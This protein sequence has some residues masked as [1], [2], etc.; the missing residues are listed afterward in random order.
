MSLIFSRRWLFL[1]LCFLGASFVGASYFLEYV[2]GLQ[3]CLLCWLQRWTL[4][5]FA[6]IALLCFFAARRYWLSFLLNVLLLLVNLFG[7]FFAGRQVWLQHL[8][9]AQGYSCLPN[10]SF[11]LKVYSLKKIMHLSFIGTPNC[12]LVHGRILGLSLAQWALIVFVGLL[13]L[14][15]Y[16]F[17]KNRA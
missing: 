5:T 2:R 8:P 14:V 1:W 7:I 17:R 15:L 9:A 16:Q 13:F 3:P 12:G 11:L 6:V 10:V 4:V